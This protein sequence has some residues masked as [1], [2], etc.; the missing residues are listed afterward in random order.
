MPLTGLTSGSQ[1]PTIMAMDAQ[2]G[3]SSE[4]S[5]L[6]KARFRVLRSKAGLVQRVVRQIEGQILSGRLTVGAKLPPERELSE[7]L[8]VSRTVVREAVR[9]LVT[10]GLLETRHGIGT[11]VRAVERA[12][13][14]KPLTLL[15]RT[16]GETVTNE[17]LHQIRLILE[18]ENAKIAAEQ[19]TNADVKDLR[20]IAAEM[21]SAAADPQRFAAKDAEF[22]RRLGLT[23]RNPLLTL[24]LDTVSDLMAEVRTLVANE[25]GVF[26]R[27]MPTHRNILECVARQDASGARR[28]M[29][30]HLQIALDIQQELVRKQ[31][32]AS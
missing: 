20:R 16:C 15:L 31:I 9:D 14:V 25:H 18:V 2:P 17:H 28:A 29:R 23:T 3:V 10:Q 8:G 24:L 30:E 4:N 6:P 7:R 19:A 12:Q 13:V 22:H 21:E 26:E 1:R 32:N 27:V 5:G 11:T